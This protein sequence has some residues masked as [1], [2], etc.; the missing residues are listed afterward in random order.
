MAK[1]IGVPS[2]TL[3]FQAAA[4]KT[5]SRSKRGYVGLMVR[6]TK[7]QGLHTITGTAQI[8]AGLGQENK[9]Y[10][11]RAFIGSDRGA[12]SR[13]TVVVIDPEGADAVKAGLKAMESSTHDYI[14]PPKD[15]TAEELATMEAW[16]RSRRERY[17]PEKLVEC[18]AAAPNDM[19]IVNFGEESVKVGEVTYTGGDYLSRIAGI[20]AG[21]PSGMS[22]TFCA[23]PE[24]STVTERTVAEQNA[25]VDAGKLILIH[26]GT[27]AKIARGVNSL[28]T[29]PAEGREDWRKI[30]IIEGMDL[31][32]YYMRTTTQNEY[33]GR[34]PNT[35]DNKCILLTAVSNYL[36]HLER[37]GV[38]DPGS[39]WCEI[40]V[41]AQAKWLSEQGVDVS[42]LTE[43]EL[44]EHQTGS[45]VFIRYGGHLVDAMEDFV[46][47]FIAE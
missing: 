6:D 27:T 15:A 39:S 23:L 10:I 37:E 28:T 45:F 21:V 40:D 24:V 19:G 13:V 11:R 34:Y 43:R 5:A 42:E 9:D 12:P 44:K 47:S 32:S 33:V 3:T 25:A 38:L 16:V 14:V 36:Q 26:D 22:S 41:E 2:L 7:E 1:N 4:S 46:G 17:F 35:Y 18:A 29:I 8:P 30:K 20:L 31:I